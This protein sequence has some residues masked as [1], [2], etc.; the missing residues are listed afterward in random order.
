MFV[1][2]RHV[3]NSFAQINDYGQCACAFVTVRCFG[4]VRSF[5]R[6]CS[7]SALGTVISQCR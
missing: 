7:I 3:G 6:L 1:D 4:M 5:A 2:D